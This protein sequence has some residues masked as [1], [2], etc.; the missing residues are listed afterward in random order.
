MTSAF[1]EPA[2][3]PS[4]YPGSHAGG[5]E[6]KLAYAFDEALDAAVLVGDPGLGKTTLLRRLAARVAAAGHVVV[7]VFFPR[8]D[9]D[10]LL[11]F[12]DAELSGDAEGDRREARLRRIAH[13][14]RRLADENRRVVILIDDAHLLGDA[15][16]FET[17][18]LLL[19][20]R[21]REGVAF[22]VVLAGQKPLLADLARV[23]AFAQR[24]AVT[25]SLAPFDAKET[26]GYVRHRLRSA[27]RDEDLFGAEA[28]AAV[29]DRSAG[30]PRAIDR[31]CE[32]AMLVASSQGRGKVVA[33]DVG[34][35]AAEL[36]MLDRRAA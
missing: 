16:V 33:E 24:V 13:H 1:R 31:L 3:G 21:E 28:L 11:A 9:V 8:L 5:A 10:G 7:D 36:G 26:E 15:A 34:L 30:V 2:T 32:M 20:L 29:H 35:V 25:A 6:L 23:P 4:F 18:Q 17:L 14:A 22:S 19:N 27:G 12:V